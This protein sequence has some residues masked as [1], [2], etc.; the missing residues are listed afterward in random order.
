MSRR[1]SGRSL[2]CV[3]APGSGC[4]TA[5][6]LLQVKT[7]RIQEMKEAA[8]V[9]LELWVVVRLRLP[10][11]SW[12]RHGSTLQIILQETRDRA[13]LVNFAAATSQKGSETLREEV[14]RAAGCE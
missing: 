5:D 7:D 6:L 12:P 2:S 8:D 1:W 10:F 9:K 4:D 13:L 11:S 14:D 3:W